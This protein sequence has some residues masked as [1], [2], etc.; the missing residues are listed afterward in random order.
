MSK[1]EPRIPPAQEEWISQTGK[2]RCAVEGQLVEGGKCTVIAVRERGGVT[3]YPHGVEQLAVWLDRAAS[4][5]LGLFVA[6]DES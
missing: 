5:D 1:D 2:P 6:G 4:R 3:L